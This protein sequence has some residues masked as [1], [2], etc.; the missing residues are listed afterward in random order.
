MTTTTEQDKAP[1]SAIG[2]ADKLT[3]KDLREIIESHALCLDTNSETGVPADFSGK[4]LAYAEMVDARLPDAR[5]HKTN[6]KGADLTLAD[7]RGAALVQANLAEANLLGTQLQQANLQGA[8]LQ[9]STGLLRPQL[10]GANLFAAVLP[11]SISP[12]EGLKLVRETARKAGWI[13]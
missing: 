10:A 9:G 2:S 8:T 12:L 5:F 1:A 3:R 6:L 4:N 13:L 7:L 11:E